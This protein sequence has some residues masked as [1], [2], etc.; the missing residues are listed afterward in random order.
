LPACLALELDVEREGAA[1]TWTNTEVFAERVLGEFRK[2]PQSPFETKFA[3]MQFMHLVATCASVRTAKLA[4]ARGMRSSQ[5]RQ[6]R[7]F[8]SGSIV[9][10]STVDALAPDCVCRQHQAVSEATCL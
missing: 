2:R 10:P 5:K 9:P 4:L 8:L 1:K 7:P 3:K 6:S